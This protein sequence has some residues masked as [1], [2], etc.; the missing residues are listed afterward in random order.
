MQLGG[1]GTAGASGLLALLF[2]RIYGTVDQFVVKG[3]RQVEGLTEHELVMKMDPENLTVSDG[4]LLIAVMTRKA[5]ELNSWFEGNRWSP[6]KVD[7]VLW[8]VGRE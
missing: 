5:V 1:L 6:R 8:V 4:L 7:M 2:P 3:L